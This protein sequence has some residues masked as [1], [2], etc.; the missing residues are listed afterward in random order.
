[1]DKMRVFIAIELSEDIKKELGELEDKLKSVGADVK[2]VKPEKIHLTLKFLG[3]INE[4][5]P[6][7]VKD[8]VER[9]GQIK[10]VNENK[11]E[12]VKAALN[13]V[14]SNHKPFKM[15]LFKLGCFPRLEHPRVIW[16]GIDAG[17]AEVEAIAGE[18]EER[19]EGIGFPK[20]KRSFSAHLTLGRVRS[21]KGR[22]ELV[23]KIKALDV[24]SSALMEVSELVLFKSTL[25]RERS[26]YT[27]L[28]KAGL[29]D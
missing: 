18:L 7:Q 11:L 3:N 8:V 25:T 2:W 10:A 16:V 29:K 4:K 12:Q 14:S 1:M 5:K 13:D 24:K 17:C 22:K 28:H 27:A 20:E 26:I 6:D 9:A 15:G 23:E 19:L 21:P